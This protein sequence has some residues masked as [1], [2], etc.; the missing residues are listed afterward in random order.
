MDMCVQFLYYK[1]LLLIVIQDG[2]FAHFLFDVGRFKYMQH[3]NCGK[4]TNYG[5]AFNEGWAEFWAGQCYGNYGTS[6]TQYKY[7]GNVAKAL[8][9]LKGRCKASYRKMVNVLRVNRGKIHSFSAYR[10]AFGHLYKCS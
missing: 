8:R 10:A 4:R 7:E 2:N 1:F 6:P 3:H 5:F 9:A